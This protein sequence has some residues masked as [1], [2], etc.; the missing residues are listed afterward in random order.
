[1]YGAGAAPEGLLGVHQRV[2]GV[3]GGVVVRLQV[4]LAVGGGAGEA[5]A[6]GRLLHT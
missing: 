1:M 6:D 3:E 4:F 5:G 2:L